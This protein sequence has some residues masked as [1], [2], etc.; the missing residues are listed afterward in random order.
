[1]L[2]ARPL[3][4]SEKSCW[5]ELRLLERA[6]LRVEVVR[7]R[8]LSEPLEAMPKS[9]MDLME[10]LMPVGKAVICWRR[11]VAMDSISVSP[12]RSPGTV[13]PEELVVV[14]VWE[15]MYFWAV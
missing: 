10:P 11:A 14:A 1:M 13:A 8:V 4:G 12:V 5:T 15:L 3:V 7:A 9:A 2:L 6:V